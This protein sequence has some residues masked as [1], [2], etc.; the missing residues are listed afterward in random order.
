MNRVFVAIG[1]ICALLSVAF[2]AFGAH[3]L[4]EWLTPGMLANYQTGVQYQMMHSLGL[5]AVGLCASILPA[6]GHLRR[7]GWSML[8]GIIV[9]SG[10]LYV[11]S[12]T[13]ITVLGAIT[14]IGGIAFIFGWL[15]LAL[16]AWKSSSN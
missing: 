8:I 16:A 1:S 15:S 7:A 6:S 3:A 4:K 10:S 14:P 9:F 12:I 13:G 11:L 2:G 5:I